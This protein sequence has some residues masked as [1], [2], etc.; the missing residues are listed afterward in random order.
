MLKPRHVKLAYCCV[1]LRA[2]RIIALNRTSS[3]V[4]LHGKSWFKLI[5]HLMELVVSVTLCSRHLWILVLAVFRVMRQ[6]EA[7]WRLGFIGSCQVQINVLYSV[8]V[9]HH[10]LLYRFFLRKGRW[11]SELIH[12]SIFCL[13]YLQ[14]TSV[15]RS[16]PLTAWRTH[17]WIDALV[18]VRSIVR[19]VALQFVHHLNWGLEIVLGDEVTSN[20]RSFLWNCRYLFRSSC[21]KLASLEQWWGL[22]GYLVQNQF[23]STRAIIQ[24]VGR[25]SQRPHE[26]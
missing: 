25:G 11:V 5:K 12:F 24:V 18:H 17:F 2:E 16:M 22:R 7:T 6:P 21:G 8:V 4:L 23:R 19:I 13:S 3:S 9:G 20:L 10:G 14:K 26:S 15:S 1:I